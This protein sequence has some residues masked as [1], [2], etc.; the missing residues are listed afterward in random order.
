MRIDLSNLG[1]RFSDIRCG[2]CFEYDGYLYMRIRTN[3]IETDSGYGARLTDGLVSKINLEEY[4]RR[5]NL[6]V[7]EDIDRQ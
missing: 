5:I 7:I 6:K 3:H 4:V 2:D 1:I